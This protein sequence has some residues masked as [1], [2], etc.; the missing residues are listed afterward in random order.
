MNAPLRFW[1]RAITRAAALG[2]VA[3]AACRD[4]AAPTEQTP[5]F[6]GRWAGQPWTGEAS[7]FVV[8]G[9]AAGDTLYVSGAHR[10][11]GQRD[12]D[13]YVRVRALVS[14]PGTYALREDA[15]LV[16]DLVGGD[17]VT[18]TYTGSRPGAGTLFIA[19]YGGPGGVVEGTLSFEAQPDRSS[20]P[21]GSSA[22]FEDGWFRATIQRSR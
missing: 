19:A 13:Q 8:S 10:M 4:T 5:T 18:S 21:Y 11:A 14:A 9:G 6:T 3:A 7:A 15:V 12:V 1:V 2:L 20:A 17:G 22:R 16:L